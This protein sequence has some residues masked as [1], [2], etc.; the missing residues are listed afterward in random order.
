MVA[1]PALGVPEIPGDD[2]EKRIGE[3]F[4]LGQQGLDIE[5]QA[6]GIGPVVGGGMKGDY[7]ND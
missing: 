3:S 4:Q 1:G 5:V 7:G 6:Q 2:K